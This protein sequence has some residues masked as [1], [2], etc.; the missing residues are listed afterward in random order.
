MCCALTRV[1]AY[2][3]VAN[4]RRF[5]RRLGMLCRMTL[6]TSM[7]AQYVVYNDLEAAETRI[8]LPSK[9]HNV[10]V[11]QS[12]AAQGSSTLDYDSVSECVVLDEVSPLVP[13]QSC[14]M[15]CIMISPARFS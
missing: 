4:A 6:I 10:P 5:H 14:A 7:E 12:A 8:L 2:V 15:S 3:S 13:G 11:S 9:V 1:K